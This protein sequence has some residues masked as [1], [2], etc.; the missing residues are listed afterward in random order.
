MGANLISG[1]DPDIFDESVNAD[2][3]LSL[4]FC[5]SV[6][7]DVKYPALYYLFPYFDH[8]H[9]GKNDSSTSNIYLDHTQPPGEEYIADTYIASKNSNVS[10]NNFKAVPN[11]D[12]S[13][14]ATAFVPR[15]T[16]FSD[17]VL[18]T[19]AS[20][21]ALSDP[22]TQPFTISI[23]TGTAAGRDVT[24]LDKGMYDGRELMGLRMIDIDIN[25]LSANR[26]SGG[27]SDHWLADEDGIAYAFREDAVREDTI[28]RPKASGTTWADCDT[29]SEVY[30]NENSGSYGVVGNNANCRMKT[31]TSSPFLQDPPLTTG[32]AISTKPIDFY[33]DP[34]R[35]PYGFRLVNGSTLNRA[36]D[37]LSGM[38]FVSDNMVYIKGDFN[39][40]TSSA[41]NPSAANACTN[42]IEE[43]VTDERLIANNCSNS[44]VTF[45][46]GRSNA[47]DNF[48]NPAATNPSNSDQW[49]PVEI[50]GDA[51]GVLSANFQDG[52]IDE[53]FTL[54][55]T[56]SSN[57]ASGTSSYQNQNRLKNN[58]SRSPGNFAIDRNG[59]VIN[60]A[61]GS[62]PTA[63]PD[64]SFI[65]VGT[66]ISGTN[67][68]YVNFQGKR[69]GDLQPATRTIVNAV[70]I[71]GII[72]SQAGQSYGGM[73]NFP[74]FLEYWAGRDLIIS[75]GFFQL[76]FSTSA[77]AP[78]DPDAWEPGA[79]PVV[80]SR[81]VSLHY[82]APNR[83]WGYDVGLQYAPAGPIAERFVSVDRP[84]SEFYRDLPVDDPY[85]QNLRCATFNS[86]QIDA[87]ATCPT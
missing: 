37:V 84:R 65:D 80:S 77:T 85:V 40:H 51:V 71:S 31:I 39:L 20:S 45:Y 67:S 26:I 16:D 72:P 87:N 63:V 62:G 34:D 76:N 81:D 8:D 82:G 27:S 36:D 59:T 28:V 17:W 43:F 48:A 13:A 21:G 18:P 79:D 47:N 44:S 7:K 50:V 6:G 66:A 22:D 25:K 2:I 70:F 54:A 49:R 57:T 52:N 19:T 69:T 12:I 11:A 3:G 75:G 86:N 14:I 33:A 38:T 1:C 42:L 78:F 41:F 73:H 61:S 46:G 74:R 23:N 29:W 9:D 10:Q 56:Q 60:L 24:F 83:I 15:S 64:T 68:D 58:G 30:T 55:R 4:T 32:T 53:M 35:R 5:K